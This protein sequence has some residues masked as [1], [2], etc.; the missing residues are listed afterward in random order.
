M[1]L[2]IAVLAAA[3]CSATPSLAQPPAPIWQ[4]W[5]AGADVGG[6]TLSGHLV[7]L[8]SGQTFDGS[9]KSFEAGLYGGY[10]W[11]SGPW[12]FGFETDWTHSFR[13]VNDLDMFSGRLRAG[14]TFDQTLI[15]ATAGIATENRFLS[16]TTINGGTITKS[17]VE[18]QH[19][20]FIVGGGFETRLTHNLSL[21]GEALYFNGGSQTY[22]FPAVAPFAAP[23]ATLDFDQII[24]RAGLTYQFN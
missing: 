20:G 12:V 17:T 19:T 13:N 5:Y 18:K 15:F 16:W 9:S 8:N 1:R 11:Q 3:V 24:Y 7:Q 2:L 10:N 21:R 14:W 23:S 4:G 22:N 6:E